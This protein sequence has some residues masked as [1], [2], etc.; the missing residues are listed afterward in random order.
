MCRESNDKGQVLHGTGSKTLGAGVHAMWHNTAK[1]YKATSCQCNDLLFLKIVVK[2][3][4]NVVKY[5]CR[6]SRE[7]TRTACTNS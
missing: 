1:L 4:I 6:N 2:L 5:S 7:S 3:R